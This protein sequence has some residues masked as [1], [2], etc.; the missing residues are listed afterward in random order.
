MPRIEKLCWDPRPANMALGT[1]DMKS[2][3]CKSCKFP[4]KKNVED[5]VLEKKEAGKGIVA[6][7]S[8]FNYFN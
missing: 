8:V 6:S 5:W 4:Q 3:W 1:S 7:S 2:T